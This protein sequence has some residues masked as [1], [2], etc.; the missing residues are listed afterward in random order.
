M[1]L[2][3]L[4]LRTEAW[5]HGKGI[6]HYNS[7]QALIQLTKT[8]EELDELVEAIN[9][10][11]KGPTEEGARLHDIKLELGDILVTLVMASSCL[12]MDLTES[13]ELA[14]NKINKRTGKVVEGVFVKDEN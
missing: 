8:R 12:Q 9:L 7:G 10:M 11:A 6:I 1:T 2:E 4:V 13:L 3:Q 14:Y 5:G